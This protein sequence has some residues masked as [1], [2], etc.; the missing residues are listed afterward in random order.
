MGTRHTFE[1]PYQ[2]LYQ[3]EVP[4]S[5]QN[6]SAMTVYKVRGQKLYTAFTKITKSAMHKITKSP[7]KPLAF[8]VYK[9][10]KK[11]TIAGIPGVSNRDANG[12]YVVSPDNPDLFIKEGSP[13]VID[14]RPFHSGLYLDTS[15]TTAVQSEESS[16]ISVK[17]A[18][19]L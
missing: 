4:A 6:P 19:E 15:K 5:S 11:V 10:M 8:A 17:A 14:L 3:P 9:R 12:I 2:L 1:I 16:E 13:F 18:E 7:Y